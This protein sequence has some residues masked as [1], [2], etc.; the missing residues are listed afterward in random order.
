ML[1]AQ[2]QAGQ[3]YDFFFFDA[4]GKV[5]DG[6]SAF[7]AWNNANF[8]SYR[9]TATES[10]PPGSFIRL[11]VPADA[12]RW[13]FRLR[14]ASLSGSTLVSSGDLEPIVDYEKVDRPNR[15]AGNSSSDA[16]SAFLTGGNVA[17]TGRTFLQARPNTHVCR[18]KTSVSRIRMKTQGGV[19]PGTIRFLVFR[20]GVKVDET[21]TFTVPHTT[22]ANSQLTFDLREPLEMER[23]DKIGVYHYTASTGDST[24][25]VKAIAG[26]LI[27]YADGDISTESGLTTSLSTYTL[28]IEYIGSGPDVCFVGDSIMEGFNGADKYNGHFQDVVDY[29]G[30]LSS[31][32]SWWVS[33]FSRTV[34]SWQNLGKGSQTFAWMLS[35]G[36]PECLLAQPKTIVLHCG[37]ND[38]FQGRTWAS[39]ESDINGIRAIVPLTTH[40]IID[41][42]LPWSNGSSANAITVRTWNANLATWCLENNATLVRCHDIFKDPD[43]PDDL[44]PAYD[45]DGVHLTTQGVM[46]LARLIANAIDGQSELTAIENSSVIAREKS[47][48]NVQ[49]LL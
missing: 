25:G 36:V 40:L 13:Q 1:S 45:Q 28:L 43:S 8:V 44:L 19:S 22:T 11:D 20:D 49:A 32:I 31:D 9:M 4:D 41:E 10:S 42:I 14:D 47:V 29:G 38:V 15:V 5:W 16:T 46:L 3:L 33:R 26:G 18:Q 12:V 35:T 21:E 39:I 30:E 17:G 2:G 37:V 24:L 27:K 23:G 48:I 34:E 7:V 6:V